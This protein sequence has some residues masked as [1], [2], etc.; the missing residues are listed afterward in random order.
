M[1]DSAMLAIASKLVQ[2]SS[3]SG[4]VYIADWQGSS[5]SHK[6]DHLACFVPGMLALGATTGA[7]SASRASAHMALADELLDTCCAFYSATPT[8]L[9]PGEM[10]LIRAGQSARAVGCSARTTR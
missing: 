7:V 6:M 2:R 3:P 10:R 5:L 9:A 1:F 8:G 4:Y